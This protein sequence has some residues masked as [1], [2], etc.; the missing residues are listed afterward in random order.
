ME[1][2]MAIKTE[3]RLRVLE[4]NYEYQDRLLDTLNEV[5]IRQQTQLDTMEDEIQKLRDELRGIVS[6]SDDD[7]KEPLPPHY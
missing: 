3:D 5:I 7:R 4:E 2:T 1:E 6:Q